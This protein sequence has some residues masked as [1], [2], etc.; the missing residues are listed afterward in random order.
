M[1]KGSRDVDMKISEVYKNKIA[2]RVWKD[3]RDKQHMKEA[4]RNIA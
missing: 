1:G 3:A 2:D 4:M